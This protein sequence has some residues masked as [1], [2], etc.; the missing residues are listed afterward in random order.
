METRFSNKCFR[1]EKSKRKLNVQSES[2][3]KKMKNHIKVE[4]T[5]Y[6]ENSENS[7]NLKIWKNWNDKKFCYNKGNSKINKDIVFNKVEMGVL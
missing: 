7:K 1:I 6:S 4:Y 3:K 5:E 2:K